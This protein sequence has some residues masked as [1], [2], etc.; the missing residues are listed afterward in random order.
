MKKSK[1]GK[2]V[3]KLRAEIEIL[4]ARLKDNNIVASES[5][6]LTELKN[7]TDIPPRSPKSYAVTKTET[8]TFPQLSH[9]KSDLTKTFALTLISMLFILALNF[10][11]LPQQKLVSQ[12]IVNIFQF[13]ASTLGK[14]KR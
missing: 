8:L 7:T 4:K 1:R 13:A 10:L 3:T 5:L 14:I 12:S 6:K 11:I 2:E 9:L